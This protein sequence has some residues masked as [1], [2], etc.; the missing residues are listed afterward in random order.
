ME[1]I[2]AALTLAA[3]F[4]NRSIT[5]QHLDFYESRLK[6]LNEAEVVKAI[7]H[8]A[9]RNELP[10]VAQIR[11]KCGVSQN[12]KAEELVAAAVRGIQEYGLDSLKAK[13]NLPAISI[14]A[15]EEWGGWYLWASLTEDRL[16]Y[17]KK[18]L[19]TIIAKLL[20]T[21]AIP[22]PEIFALVDSITISE[23]DKKQ[24]AAEREAIFKDEKKIEEIK[25][26]AVELAKKYGFQK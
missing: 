12:D 3:T 15:I 26:T 6:N 24:K 4:A 16:E 8:Y 18:N 23:L 10:S 25:N 2:K 22:A 7:E 21:N 11:D 20:K 17:A 13:Q 14:M 9:E 19:K 1:K 5:R